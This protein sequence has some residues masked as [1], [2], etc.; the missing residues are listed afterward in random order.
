MSPL[1]NALFWSSDR[2]LLLAE[3]VGY[4]VCGLAVVAACIFWWIRPFPISKD[5]PG[6]E[7][8]GWLGVT[9]GS[10][11]QELLKGESL[12]WGSWPTLGLELSRRYGFRTWGGPT[13]NLGFGGA[14]FYVVSPQSLE[15][16]LKDN[17][18]NYPKGK[19]ANSFEELMGQAIFTSDG[20]VW[21]FHRRV[22][23]SILSRETVAHGASLLHAKLRQVE[24][25]LLSKE[26]QVIDFQDLAYKMI[27][28]VFVKLAL[29]VEIN[30]VTDKPAKDLEA[31]VDA[32]DKLQ[33]YI[34]LRLGGIW[35]EIKKRFR[36]GECER[37]ILECKKIIDEFAHTVI[38]SAKQNSTVTEQ[39]DIVSCFLQYSRKMNEADPSEKELRDF[40]MTFVMAGRDTTAAALSWTLWELT[41]HPSHMDAI[42]EEVDRI[43]NGVF[44]A[45]NTEN[46]PFTTAVIM[47]ALRLHSP[48]PE[49]FRFAVNDD[50]LP[51]GT[52]IPA[53]SCV[54][55]SPNS[56]N[57][58]DKVWGTDADEF[59]PKRWL[60]K[61][62]PSPYKFPTFN[63][64]PRT[65]PGKS[66]AV[67][68]L[69]MSLA[70][71]LCK[72]DF[73]DIAGHTGDYQWTLVMAMK[74]GF[75]V[76]VTQR[77]AF[78]SL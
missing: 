8:S 72:F 10:E 46:L 74:G 7:R 66:L 9:L 26:G 20:E 62:E 51:D 12:E 52:F 19:L 50:T 63:A 16:I 22:V 34:H 5:L 3:F 33:Y 35:W 58:S 59:D 27:F 65:C 45:E 15:Y 13:L 48:A 40:V 47:E 55:Y 36:I 11:S 77:K 57:H 54:N 21:K 1:I 29:G 71:L 28:D 76:N 23:V 44:S 69:K 53:G 25:Y 38:E 78:V 49:L 60:S 17:C 24:D 41:R 30:Q 14:F 67:M 68:E 32:F 75:P 18:T 56:I 70:Y 64:G 61:G 43:C 42:R 31:F 37:K 39:K 6:P 4:A 73:E 2:F